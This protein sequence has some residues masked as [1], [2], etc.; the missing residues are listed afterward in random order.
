MLKPNAPGFS[1]GCT[2]LHL[3]SPQVETYGKMALRAERPAD[4]GVLKGGIV[5]ESQAVH[6]SENPPTA[7]RSARSA[8]LP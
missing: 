1:A 6:P 3:V 8:I 7:G 4:E 2:L 5:R